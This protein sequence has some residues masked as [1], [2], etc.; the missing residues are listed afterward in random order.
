MKTKTLLL[1]SFSFIAFNTFSQQDSVSNNNVWSLKQCIDYALANNLSV[2][3]SN[4]DVETASLNYK[5]AK[6]AMMPN[7]N[8]SISYGYNWGRSLNPVTYEFTTQELN[9]INP[10]ASSS[11]TLFNGFRIQNTIK[12]TQR[13]YHASEQ[14]LAK[15]KND[16]MLNI[17]SYYI[18][19]IFNKEQL[20]NARFQLA[21]SQSQ[22]DR[23]KRQVSAGALP[24]SEELNIDAQVATNEVNVANQENALV[25]SL[26][27]LKQALLL[28]ASTPLDVQLIEIEV[29]DFVLDQS[30]DQIYDLARQIMPEIRSANLRVES[31][32]Y[33]AKAAKGNLY[34]RLSLNGSINSNYSSASDRPRFI[35][36]GGDPI[37]TVEPIGFIEGTNTRVVRNSSIPS[38]TMEDGY[39]RREQLKDNIY[40]SLGLSLTIPIFNGFQA[41]Y[42]WQS[43][44]INREVA[45][46]AYTEVEQAL[47]Q[48]VETA[49]NN[50]V[51]ASK[52]YNAS[53]RQVEAREE[54][55][56]MMEQRMNAGAANSFEYQV[57]Q[58]DLFRAKSDLTRA[59]YDLIFRKKLL[60]FYQG[61]P[62]EY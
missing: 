26:L 18:N 39:G 25:L 33:A 38:G 28:P 49:Y 48:N 55:F 59:K 29:E 43:T 5:Q 50:A 41:R 17:T 14:D 11:V 13:S 27:Q 22:L 40:R 42:N 4:Y 54:A 53:L 19:V 8:G 3:R 7:L 9:S 20:E 6:W 16:V 56:R 24:R 57:S 44:V 60:D 1:L 46:I 10:G 62:L 12:Q 61:K 36:D 51:A 21:S 15:T 35:P 30:R 23:V 32:Y 58:N 45:K 47:R 34:P 52:T 31:S 2:K 37:P